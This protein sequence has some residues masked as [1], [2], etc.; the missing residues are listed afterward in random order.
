MLGVAVPVRRPGTGRASGYGSV[1]GKTLRDSRLSTLAMAGVLCLFVLAGGSAMVSAYG[2]AQTRAELA[3]L[4]ATLPPVLTGMYG[5][6]VRVDTLGGFVTW[7]YGGYLALLAGLWSILALSGT[8]ASE[9]RRGSLEFVLAAPVGRSRIAVEKVAAHVVALAGALAVLACATWASGALFGV[10]PDDAVSPAAAVGWALGIGVRALAA[11]SV[12][13]ALAAFV[14]RGAAAGFAG[15]L[16]LGLFIANSWHMAIPAFAPV[17][18]AGWF[19]W[20]A[21]HLPLAGRWDLPSVALTA[22]AATLLLAAGVVAFARRDV[23]TT[24]SLPLPAMPAILLG[25]RGPAGRAFGEALPVALGWGIGLGAFGLLM[26]TASRTFID[27]IASTPGVAGFL[28]ALSPVLD[29]TTPQGFVQVLFAD[30]G[31]VLVGLAA[32]TLVAGRSGEETA[33]RLEMVL[34][35]PLGRMRWALASGLGLL[36]ALAVVDACVALAVGIG[37]TVAGGDASAPLVGTL[38]LVLYG[39]A[40]AGV[41]FALAGLAGPSLAAPAVAIIVL[42]TFVADLL[43]DALRLPDPIRALALSTHMGRPMVGEWDLVG[44][45]ACVALAAGGLL[46]GAWGMRRRD[47]GG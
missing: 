37:V 4:A 16:M 22:C 5:E 14:G 46:V 41:G 45:A 42:A 15:A 33:G 35:T 34:A 25:I 21:G 1:F 30:F 31:F 10:T 29:M 2:T 23:G 47:L 3:Y 26:A 18:H 43:G 27:A 28:R 38:A 7:H 19:A 12:A 44:V 39:A 8:L 11:G 20:T 13:F 40:F 36:G 6:P 17:A 32:A 24:V 9:A